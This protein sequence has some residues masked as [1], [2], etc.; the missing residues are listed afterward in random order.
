MDD[1]TNTTSPDVESD[2]RYRCLVL[3]NR[4]DRPGVWTFHC[5]RCTMPVAELVNTEATALTDTMEVDNG[6]LAGVGVR[7]DGRFQGKRCSIWFY[8]NLNGLDKQDG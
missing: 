1:V 5:P 4:S 3:L 7:C 8:Y 6:H 2:R